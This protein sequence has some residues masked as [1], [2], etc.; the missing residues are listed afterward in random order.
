MRILVFDTETT[1]L[2]EGRNPS[3]IETTKWP[4][5]VQ[6]S[7]IIYD[8]KANELIS[9]YDEILKLPEDIDISE[10]SIKLHKITK[11]INQRIGVD[12]KISLYNF[13]KELQNC[14]IVV[15]HNISF[16]KRM[17]MVECIRNGVQQYFNY[18]GKKKNEFCT[19]KYGVD[20]CMIEKINITGDKYFKYPTLSELYYKLFNEI[21]LNTHDSYVDVLLCLRCYCKIIHNIDLIHNDTYKDILCEMTTDTTNNSILF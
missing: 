1:G 9:S 16:D 14:D 4:Y 17:I 18:R 13:N 10:E 8:Y 7:Y 2:P 15:G 5:I 21:P 11:E 12:R 6:L 19:M 20:I 3:I